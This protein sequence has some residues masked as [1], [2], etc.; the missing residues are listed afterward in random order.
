MILLTDIRLKSKVN[1]REK[2]DFIKSGHD[3]I[4]PIGH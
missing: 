1:V 2:D 4:M 3:E